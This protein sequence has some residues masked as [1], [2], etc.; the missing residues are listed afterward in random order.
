MTPGRKTLLF[1]TV[2]KLY[3]YSFEQK[4]SC[5]LMRVIIPRTTKSAFFVIIV[6][7][8]Y[9]AAMYSSFHM[10]TIISLICCVDG[11]NVTMAKGFC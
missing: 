7:F 5:Q 1:I 2:T 3:T 8:G 10:P 9:E 11:L 4:V 6:Y